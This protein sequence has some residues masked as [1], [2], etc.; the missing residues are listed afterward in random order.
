MT[1]IHHYNVIENSF[2]ALKIPC[3]LSVYR[4]LFHHKFLGTTDL[5]LL[6]IVF[7]FLECHI[8]GAI[9]YADSGSQLPDYTVSLCLVFFEV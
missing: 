2:S 6:S 9:Q 1:C 3:A 4:F 7:P 5:F 8:F